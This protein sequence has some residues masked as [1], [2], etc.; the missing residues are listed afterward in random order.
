MRAFFLVCLLLLTPCACRAGDGAFP[1]WGASVADVLRMR[2]PSS[3]LGEESES[4]LF[5]T[6]VYALLTE[7]SVE[8]RPASVL[9]G[10]REGALVEY[11]VCF[12]GGEKALYH[13]LKRRLQE[14]CRSYEGPFFPDMED[15]FINKS[16]TSISLLLQGREVMLYVLDARAYAALRTPATQDEKARSA[17]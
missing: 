2:A 16:R 7:E 12:H 1:A 15:A 10:F 13:E 4:L 11:V 5:G 8:G 6:P 17:P 3:F 9:Y 14:T